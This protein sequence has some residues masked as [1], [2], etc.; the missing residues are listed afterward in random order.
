MYNLRYHLAS[1]VAVFLALAL[2]LVL[3]GLVV[4]QGT[5]DAQQRAIVSGLQRDFG[6]LNDDNQR[7]SAEIDL[8][9][10][11][12]SQMTDAWVKG[13]L[14][15]MTIVILTSGEKSEGL[16]PAITSVEKAGGTAAVVTIVQPGMGLSDKATS[17]ALRSIVGTQTELTAA[18]AASLTAEWTS[19]AAKR[20]VTDALV[21]TG[22]ITVTGLTASTAA[23]QAVTIAAFERKPDKA[24]LEVAKAYAAAGFYALGAQ[25][26]TSGT[27]VAAAAAAAKLSAFDTLGTAPGQFTLVALFT[28][29]QQGYYTLGSDQDPK[30]PPVPNP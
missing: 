11:F 24:A 22:A 18:V 4:G 15:G 8:Q 9:H 10:S 21:K 20:P 13:R 28:G 5:M 3:G 7:L 26:P 27:G 23:T 2:G 12:S 19:A 25:T 14:A 29:G 17:A 1:L 16:Q 30:F 6:R